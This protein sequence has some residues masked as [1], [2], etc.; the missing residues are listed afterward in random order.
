[1][2]RLIAYHGMADDIGDINTANEVYKDIGAIEC[3]DMMQELMKRFNASTIHAVKRAH[4]SLGHPSNAA[5]AVATQHAGAP[6]EWIQCARLVQCEICLGRGP[7]RFNEVVCPDVYYITWTRKERE[8]LAIMNEFTRYQVDY[9]ISQETL[10]KESKLWEKPWIASKPETMRMEMGGSQTAKRTRDW[11]SKRGIKLDL[12]PKGA[13]H[14]GQLSK[15][16]LQFAEDLLK[17]AL[18]MTTS[19]RNA[20]KNVHGFSPAALILGTQPKIPGALCDRDFGLS[21]QAA[22]VDTKGEVHEMMIRRTAAATAII[23]ANCSR[24]VRAALLARSRPTRRNYEIGEWVYFW[25]PEQ[26]QGWRSAAGAAQLWRQ[27]WRQRST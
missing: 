5:L 27:Q 24:G 1:M 10:L 23:D 12:A 18:R 17:T 8:I 19:Q 3:T 11:M 14:R 15:R 16:H 25:R 26:T 6:A 2:A 7:E 21:E 22:L 9:P 4:V 20:L 13:R